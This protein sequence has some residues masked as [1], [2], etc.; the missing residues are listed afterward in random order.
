[1]PDL[2]LFLPRKIYP[3][4]IAVIVIAVTASWVPLALIFWYTQI[5]HESPRIH[6]FQD[7][8]N[9]PRL[10]AQQSSPI[11]NDGRAMRIAPAGTVARGE[12]RGDD[13]F[14]RGYTITPASNPGADG[15]AGQPTVDYF[16]GFPEGVE[17]DDLFLQRGQEKFNTFCSPCHGMTG[18]GNGPVNERAMLL[19]N[20]DA[21]K[22][23]GTVWVPTKSLHAIGDDKSLTYGE[24]IYPNGQLFT[25][26]THGKGNM[27]GYGHA[28]APEDRWAV[29]AYVRALQLSQNVDQAKQA[30]ANADAASRLAENAPE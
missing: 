25:V 4:S 14:D 21:S 19:L 26:I 22:S 13:H 17:V 1:M 28:I 15:E 8:D 30:A 24:D 16:A 20:G 7:M 9:Q 10:N 2:R 11:F 18:Y 27:A 3:I 12:L 23:L 5:Y 6:L 29:V